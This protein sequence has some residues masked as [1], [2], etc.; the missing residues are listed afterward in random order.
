MTTETKAWIQVHACV[1]LWGFTGILGKLIRMGAVPLVFW[2]MSIVTVALLSMTRVRRALGALTRPVVAAM[3]GNGVVLA[4][5]W[6]TLYQAIKVSNASV[7]ITCIA[8]VPVFLALIEP[9]IARRPFDPRELGLGVVAVPGVYLVV[10]GTPPSMRGGVVLA[11]ISA[12]L[13][14][15]FSALNKKMISQAD[16]AAMTCL[17]VGSGALFVAICAW[18]L[19]HDGAAL[20]LPDA[21]DGLLLLVLASVCTL[22][23]FVVWLSA[24]RHL[25]AFASTLVV[26]LEPVYTILLA[27]ALFGEHHQLDLR[28]Y[29]G[30]AILVGSMFAYPFL[31][32]RPI[33]PVHSDSR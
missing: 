11:V 4:L 9:K 6:L 24:L 2:R 27:M 22:L 15:V 12:W 10:G 32:R 28:F 29:A 19:P 33:T 13:V 16:A 26:N 30:V 14:A 23:P 3:C 18:L 25:S 21:R 17:E 7:A 20:P 8:L 5:H 1:V 31:R